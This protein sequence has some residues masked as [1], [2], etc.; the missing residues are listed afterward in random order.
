MS[1]LTF[2]AY[3][4]LTLLLVFFIIIISYLLIFVIVLSFI[5]IN[6]SVSHFLT[7][8]MFICL[9]KVVFYTQS[10]YFSQRLFMRGL[11]ICNSAPFDIFAYYLCVFCILEVYNYHVNKFDLNLNCKW[12]TQGCVVH[13]LSRM[14]SIVPG[15]WIVNHLKHFSKYLAQLAQRHG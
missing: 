8:E 11:I 6:I 14:Y 10:C 4:L 13:V 2:L 1:C 3:F 5:I 9:V 7:V 15:L 12:I